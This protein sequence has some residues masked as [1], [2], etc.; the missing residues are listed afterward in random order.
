[1]IAAGALYDCTVSVDTFFVNWRL[2][3]GQGLVIT[4]VITVGDHELMAAFVSKMN[5]CE[6]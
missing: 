1:M 6:F 5:E 3:T 4:Y 2:Q